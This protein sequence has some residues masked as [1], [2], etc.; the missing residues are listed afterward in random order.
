ML[1]WFKNLFRRKCDCKAIGSHTEFH[2]LKALDAL[3]RG[4]DISDMPRGYTR[5]CVYACQK[6][7]D[8]ICRAGHDERFMFPAKD[9]GE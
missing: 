1:K 3:G 9:T 2:T 5:T 6:R 4:E 7:S 8:R